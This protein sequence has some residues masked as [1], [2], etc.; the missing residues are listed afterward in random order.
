MNGFKKFLRI[1]AAIAA[2][3]AAVG[4]LLYWLERR[5]G[6][7][8][9][10]DEY[11]MGEDPELDAELDEPTTAD[12]EKEE[13]AEKGGLEF[14]EDDIQVLKTDLDLKESL[15][16][17]LHVEFSFL[18]LPNEVADI[19]QMLAEQ[20]C[21]ST[22]DHEGSVLELLLTG[23][24]DDAELDEFFAMLSMLITRYGAEYIGFGLKATQ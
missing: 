17:G 22:Y 23:P 2:V 16:L 4:A 9:D 3:C 20:G 24:K 13:E 6:Y 5:R 14:L 8:E 18:V 21:S 11:L 1:A 7:I 10:L 12:L 15:E 19:Q